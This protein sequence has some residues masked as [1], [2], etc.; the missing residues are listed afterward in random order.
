ML[1]LK[2]EYFGHLMQRANSLEKPLVLGKIEGRR[3]GQQR[4]K[5]LNGIIDSLDMSLGKLQ[6]VLK[7]REAWNDAVHGVTESRTDLATEQ[8][9]PCGLAVAVSHD[10]RV[11]PIFSPG[12]RDIA[13]SHSYMCPQHHACHIVYSKEVY[14]AS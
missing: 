14:S 12:G 4:M 3:R 7:D 8:Q 6:G 11:L 2:L 5:W 10:C 9:Q 13:P 1:K